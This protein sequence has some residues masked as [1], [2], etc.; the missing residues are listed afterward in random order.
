MISSSDKS[1]TPFIRPVSTLV[2]AMW[3]LF[4][5][6]MKNSLIFTMYLNVSVNRC[7]I[8]EYGRPAHK[9]VSM[10]FSLK[11]QTDRHRQHPFDKKMDID[12]LKIYSILN[13]LDF[14]KSRSQ[15]NHQKLKIHNEFSICHLCIALVNW[16]HGSHLKWKQQQTI[17]NKK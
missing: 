4:L 3:Q 5:V 16:N 1:T 14:R 8:F 12:I 11:K 15:F 2:S 7:N 6:W 13:D 9:W 10:I 17:S